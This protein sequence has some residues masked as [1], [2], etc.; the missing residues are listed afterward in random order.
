MQT[1]EILSKVKE[2][3]A[4]AGIDSELNVKDRQLTACFGLPEE[5]T[6]E[7]FIC[8]SSSEKDMP[9]ITLH[10]ICLVVDKGPF[11]GIKK[12]MALELLILNET[13]NFARYGVQEEDDNYIIVASY[14][15]LLDGLQPKT[16]AATLECI[17]LAADTY[18]AKFGQDV[19]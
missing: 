14:D 10:S 4:E 9:A 15:L 13:L 5:R 1:N 18:E 11:K 17:A 7:V 8:D 6:Q 12:A 19:Y 16:L 2:L 3:A